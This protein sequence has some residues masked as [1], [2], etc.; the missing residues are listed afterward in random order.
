MRVEQETRRCLQRQTRLGGRCR[1]HPRVRI[2]AKLAADNRETWGKNVEVPVVQGRGQPNA[3]K[4][5]KRAAVC[6]RRKKNHVEFL[7]KFC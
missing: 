5:A 2:T 7:Q 1:R 3:P 4:T 6:K